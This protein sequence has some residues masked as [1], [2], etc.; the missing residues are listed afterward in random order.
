ML[1]FTVVHVGKPPKV[2]KDDQGGVEPLKAEL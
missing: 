2:V 1:S